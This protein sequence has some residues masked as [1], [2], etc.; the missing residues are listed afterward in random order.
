MHICKVLSIWRARL[1]Q[2]VPGTTGRHVGEGGATRSSRGRGTRG[3]VGSEERDAPECC[4]V[5][6]HVTKFGGVT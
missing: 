6:L 2:R 3:R 5:S 1:P 4:G